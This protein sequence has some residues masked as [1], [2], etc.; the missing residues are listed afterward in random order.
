MVKDQAGNMHKPKSIQEEIT[1]Y[2]IVNE[3][4][5]PYIINLNPVNKNNKN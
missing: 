3:Y 1:R 4:I 2:K 5:M